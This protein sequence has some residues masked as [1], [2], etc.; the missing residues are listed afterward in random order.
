MCRLAAFPSFFEK[1]HA[2][3]I[4]EEF[5]RGNTDGTGVVY[6]KDGEFVNQRW[7][8]SLA[9]V[10]SKQLPLLDHMPYDGWTIAHLRAGTHGGNTVEN[11]HPFIKNKWA[12]AHNGVWSEH[13]LVRAALK[14]HV[15]FEG[16]TDSEVAAEVFA[17]VGPKQFSKIVNFGGV[18]LGLNLNGELWVV[19]TSGD[20]EMTK[21]KYGMLLA[22]TLPLCLRGEEQPDGWLKFDRF[23]DLL[24]QR[25]TKYSFMSE[26]TGAFDPPGMVI[27]GNKFGTVW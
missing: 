2:I 16:E 20:L 24:D 26:P 3:K 15:K 8:I 13:A 22:S 21:T 5:S 12:I 9:K 11:T 25:E 10:M 4:L 27:R 19:K 7:P 23:G 18:F 6:V 17:T 14:K 1:R